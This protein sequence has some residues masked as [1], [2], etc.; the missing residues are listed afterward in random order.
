MKPSLIGLSI[1]TSF[2][3]VGCGSGSGS[4]SNTDFILHWIGGSANSNVVATDSNIFQASTLQPKITFYG[5]DSKSIVTAN[6]SFVINGA[7][8]SPSGKKLSLSVKVNGKDQSYNLDDS[9]IFQSPIMLAD[10]TSTIDFVVSEAN[11]LKNTKSIQ[12]T[13]K[14]DSK[15]ISDISL[16]ATDYIEGEAVDLVSKVGFSDTSDIAKVDILSESSNKTISAMVDDGK[17]PDEINADGVY[18]AKFSYVAG[19]GSNCFYAVVTQ[20]SGAQYQSSTICG[21]GYKKQ[22]NETVNTSAAIHQSIAYLMSID[23]T[24]KS[25][26]EKASAVVKKLKSNSNYSQTFKTLYLDSEGSIFWTTKDGVNGIYLKSSDG[27]SQTKDLKSIDSAT[28]FYISPHESDFGSPYNLVFSSVFNSEVFDTRSPLLND[29]VRTTFDQLYGSGI[30]HI[31]THGGQFPVTINN[32]TQ[33]LT[34]LSTGEKAPVSGLT[35]S[36]TVQGMVSWMTGGGMSPS[37]LDYNNYM[38][39]VTFGYFVPDK[40]GVNVVTSRYLKVK[41]KGQKLQN[42]LVFVD[43]CHSAENTNNDLRDIFFSMGAG[44]YIGYIN[45]VYNYYA[46]TFAGNFY[47]KLVSGETVK[48]SFDKTIASI[49]ADDLKYG[50]EK[51]H[52]P[53]TPR[54]FFNSTLGITDLSMPDLSLKNGGFEADSK[55]YAPWQGIGD[56][57]VISKLG[58]FSP[59]SGVNTGI[60]STGLGYTTTSG[61]ISQRVFVQ[62]TQSHLKFSW[63]YLSEEFKQYCGSIYQDYF[64]V[65]VCKKD[66]SC[67]VIFSKKVDDLCDSV[68][69]TNVILNTDMP[70][71]YGTGWQNQVIDISAYRG[72][73]ITL[74]F[75]ASDIGDSAYDTAALLDE[76]S[77]Y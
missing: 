4:E 52:V 70:A 65:T 55:S 32:Q 1:V 74:K 15:I 24:D 31:S 51:E 30:L 46:I 38:N 23:K 57:R 48:S 2:V 6:S 73:T 13:Y 28:F 59:A 19:A 56:A 39:E 33:M 61:E 76:I 8:A 27:G 12:V 20:K 77:I 72:K 69:Q 47:E 17:L 45:S 14:K 54:V 43:A 40:H 53:S 16:S 75:E 71:V 66:G 3:L 21:D 60:L 67:D 50:T 42:S 18:T 5:T 62:N 64:N 29:R 58:Q 11:G 25:P 44:A 68:V 41:Y 49:G 34:V 7:I 37:C 22:T 35:C 36:N 26:T 10:G 63:N 9:G